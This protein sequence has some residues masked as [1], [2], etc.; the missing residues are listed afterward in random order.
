MRNV[1]LFEVE[2]AKLS[3]VTQYQVL[4]CMD[5]YGYTRRCGAPTDYM[6]KI[7]EHRGWRRIRVYQISNN[8]TCFIRLP[9]ND[10]CPIDAEGVRDMVKGQSNAS[11][12]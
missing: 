10:F 2:A 11:N 1:S 8:G 4:R 6:V 3:P 12:L 7:R 5:S 9:G